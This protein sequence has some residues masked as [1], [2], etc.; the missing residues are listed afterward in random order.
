MKQDESINH[1]FFECDF[2][3]TIGDYKA[4]E[5]RSGLSFTSI[6]VA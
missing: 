3:R 2:A 5:G 1:M 6:R 4:I